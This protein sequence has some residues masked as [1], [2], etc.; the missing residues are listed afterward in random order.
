MDR[1]PPYFAELLMQLG[2]ARG[3]GWL[4]HD[5]RVMVGPPDT[6]VSGSPGQ[7]LSLV[8]KGF[9]GGERGMLILTELGREYVDAEVKRRAPA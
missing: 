2:Q 7:W 5:Y 9:V 6:P 8:A 1:L 4:D 3:I